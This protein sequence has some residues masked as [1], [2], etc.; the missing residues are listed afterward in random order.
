M[1]VRAQHAV[2]TRVGIARQGR[3]AEVGRHVLREEHGANKREPA[4]PT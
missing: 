4:L 1:G 2:A 3:L